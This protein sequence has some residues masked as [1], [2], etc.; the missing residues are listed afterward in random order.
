MTSGDLKLLREARDNLIRTQR[1]V[2][3]TTISNLPVAEGANVLR[4]T[5]KLSAELRARQLVRESAVEEF[6]AYLEYEVL[7][8]N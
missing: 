8:N 5:K 7:G 6:L 1:E 2:L 3:N 4:A